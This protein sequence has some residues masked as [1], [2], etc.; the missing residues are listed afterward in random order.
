VNNETF[1]ITV[2]PTN[3]SLNEAPDWGIVSPRCNCL[4]LV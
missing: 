3:F 4:A 1:T 2:L